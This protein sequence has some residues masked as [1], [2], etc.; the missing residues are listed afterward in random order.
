MRKITFKKSLLIT[1]V[2]CAWQVG[3]VSSHELTDRLTNT[4]AVDYFIAS[5]GEAD[6]HHLYVQINDMKVVDGRQFSA[7]VIKGKEIASTTNP[8]GQTSPAI[9]VAG[10]PGAYHL[11]VSQ[12]AGGAK[13]ANYR[14]T[15]H[16]EDSSN[17]HLETDS[18]IM[19]NQP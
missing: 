10:G 11:Y 4:D 3:I 2:L 18:M 7:L 14:L 6:N 19:G 17:I 13:A 15:F 12:T 1:G 5:C 16:C 9:K 8:D